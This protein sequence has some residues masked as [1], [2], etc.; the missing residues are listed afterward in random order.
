MEIPVN[1]GTAGRAQ[2][3]LEVREKLDIHEGDYLIIR[4]E[5]VLKGGIEKEAKA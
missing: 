2:I 3:P 1:V 5:K 4:I